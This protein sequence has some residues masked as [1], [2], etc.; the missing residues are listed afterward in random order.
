MFGLHSLIF[1][2]SDSI[3]TGYYC[4]L[5][6]VHINI[7]CVFTC[8]DEWVQLLVYVSMSACVCMQCCCL[9]IVHWYISIKGLRLQSTKCSKCTNVGLRGDKLNDHQPQLKQYSSCV[10]WDLQTWGS[11]YLRGRLYMQ[12]GNGTGYMLINPTDCSF[13]SYFNYIMC[14]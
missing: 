10:F 14:I 8:I 5:L 12:G 11:E 6:C 4:C 9:F 13:T 7:I 2:S 1:F 3:V